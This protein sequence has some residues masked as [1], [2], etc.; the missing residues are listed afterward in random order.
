MAVS[1]APNTVTEGTNA[2]AAGGFLG[3]VDDAIGLRPG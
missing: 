3:H 1:T 2:A